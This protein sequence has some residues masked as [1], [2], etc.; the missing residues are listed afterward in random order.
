MKCILLCAGYSMNEDLKLQ[1][2][3][4]SLIELNGKPLI[5]YTIEK[6]EKLEDINEIF[7]IT[8]GLY[9]PNFLQWRAKYSFRTK[10]KIINDNTTSSEAK[11][12]AIGDIRYTINSE[13]IKE[14]IMVLAGDIYFDFSFESFLQFYHEKGYS[15][16]A[17]MPIEDRKDLSKYGI[18]EEENG[19]VVGMQEKSL[20]PKGNMLSLSAYIYSYD[21]LRDFEYYLSEGNKTTYPGYFLE[22]LYLLKPV[23]VYKIDGCYYD[24]KSLQSIEKLEE[25]LVH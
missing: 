21:V 7:V 24:V 3:A 4:S 23:Y 6:L 17:G 11:L 16:V 5:N 19:L 25:K 9:Y 20:N 8:N 2:T 1:E 12:G 18:L 14:D 13:D 10:V 22:Y 15:V